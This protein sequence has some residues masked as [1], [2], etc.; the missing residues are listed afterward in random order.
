MIY[1]NLHHRIFRYPALRLACAG[2]VNIR[3]GVTKGIVEFYLLRTF[4]TVARLGHLTRAAEKLHLSQPTVSGQIRA[5]EEELGVRLFERT[6]RGVKLTRYSEKLLPKAERIVE[7]ALE[8]LVSAKALREDLSGKIRIGTIIHPDLVRIAELSARM[9]A[10]CPRVEIEFHHGLSGWVLDSLR[11]H[12]LDAGFYV[13]DPP[14]GNISA[15]H[16][17][18]LPLCVVAPASFRDRVRGAGWKEIAALPWIWTPKLGAYHRIT[19]R[20]FREHKLKPN[21]VME[22]DRE[23][24]LINLV[25]AG[26][27]LSL[28]R[29]EVAQAAVRA[30]KVVIWDKGRISP[31]LSFVSLRSRRHDPLIQAINAEI[32]KVWRA[33]SPRTT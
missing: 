6:P 18:D 30:R 28:T 33:R 24:T 15:L 10:R 17:A 9:R 14:R 8:L 19:S 31:P 1:S 7:A 5:L 25:T 27:G 12:T 32:A 4:I 29:T 23:S 2:F 21:I 22:A 3:P 16:L 20:M 11:K 13:G 26:M